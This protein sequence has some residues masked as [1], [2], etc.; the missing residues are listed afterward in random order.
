MALNMKMPPPEEVIANSGGY[1]VAYILEANLGAGLGQLGGLLAAGVAIAMTFCGFSSIASAGRMLFAFSRDD[2]VP[3]S[4]WLKKVS[5]RFRS[6]YMAVITISLFSWLLILLVYVL[7]NALGGDPVFLIAG[8]TGV[9]TVLLYWAYGL[10]IFLGLRGDQDWRTRQTWSLGAWSRPL[11]WISV[12]WI[13]LITPLFLYPFEL[14]AA[15]L[16]TVVG[17]LVLLLVY[18]FAWARRRFRGPVPQG[19]TEELEAIERE[20]EQ[21]AESLGT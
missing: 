6:P 17:F 7:F 15:A 19:T 10:C 9:S 2:G 21:A 12:I 16:A 8:I 11:A 18:Y 20:F 4:R 3:G 13:I 1:G 14:N 5:H